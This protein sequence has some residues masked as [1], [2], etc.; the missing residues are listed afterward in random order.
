MGCFSDA[1]SASS[2]VNIYSWTAQSWDFWYRNPR[3]QKA[4]KMTH[5]FH[6]WGMWKTQ[7][8]RA[9]IRASPPAGKGWA[10]LSLRQPD[11]CPSAR[12]RDYLI[13]AKPFRFIWD[14]NKQLKESPAWPKLAHPLL[15][16]LSKFSSLERRT[17]IYFNP[18]VTYPLNGFLTHRTG[19]LIPTPWLPQE[20]RSAL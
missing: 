5:S 14:R 11:W 3:Q 17:H 19:D 9:R 2:A 4:L 10:L 12:G 1:G 20:I 15:G 18:L 16:N 7:L 6:S 8:R 13:I